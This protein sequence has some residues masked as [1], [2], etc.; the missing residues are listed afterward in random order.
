MARARA[1]VFTPRELVP[2]TLLGIT[3]FGILIAPLN[4]G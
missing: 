3:Q 4:F 2:I 1:C